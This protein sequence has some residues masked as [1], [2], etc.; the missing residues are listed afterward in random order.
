MKYIIILQLFFAVGISKAQAQIQTNDTLTLYKIVFNSLSKESSG[1]QVYNFSKKDA[2]QKF[3]FKYPSTFDTLRHIAWQN[4]NWRTFLAGVDTSM[5]KEYPLAT[6]GKPWFK[7]DTQ[8]KKN[9]LIF[10]PVL[11]SK[12]RTMA[13]VIVR[14]FGKEPGSGIAFYLTNSSTGWIIEKS[15]TYVFYD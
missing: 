4:K 8:S 3:D 1:Y 5:V 11:I 2:F 13:L 15:D 9:N 12:D 14:I 10:A 6:N 7:K